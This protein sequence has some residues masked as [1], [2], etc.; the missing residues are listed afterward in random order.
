MREM[1]WKL[2]VCVMCGGG[3]LY[4]HLHQTNRCTHLKMKLPALE[5]EVREMQESNH[6]LAYQIEQFENPSHLIELA[7]RPEFGHL[8]H[9]LLREVL[10]VSEEIA[11]NET[12]R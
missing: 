4:A 2:A 6:R 1:F 12:S 9:P 5:T 7:R 3:C 11:C 10:T 8:R